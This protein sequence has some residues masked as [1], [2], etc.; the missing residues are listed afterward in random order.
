MRKTNTTA[1][2]P[3]ASGVNDKGMITNFWYGNEIGIT[4]NMTVIICYKSL[5]TEKEYQRSS[6]FS[7]TWKYKK[8][9][10][11]RTSEPAGIKQISYIKIK[12]KIKLPYLVTLIYICSI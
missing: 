3:D 9:T 12:T 4:L 7:K 6:V 5:V 11:I 8:D 2:N 1:L 10:T